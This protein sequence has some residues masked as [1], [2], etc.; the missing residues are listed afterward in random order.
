MKNW[1]TLIGAALLGL[2]AAAI[3]V[4]RGWYDVSASSGHTEAV[5]R[6][7]A[8]TMERSVRQRAAGIQA[9]AL[10]GAALAKRGA[11]C[12]RDHCEQC[13]GG[14]GV[15]PGP[16][17]MGLQPLPGQ[18]VDTASRFT[19]AEIYWIT[20]HGIKM[21]GMPAWELRM[22]DRDLWAVT[23]FVAQ[24]PR[25]TPAAYRDTTAANANTCP[26]INETC[27]TGPCP[28]AATADLA[29]LAP[30]TSNEAARLAFRQYGCVGCH[31]IP[32]IVGFEVH[33]GPPLHGWARRT[34]IA[35]R[36]PN[37]ADDLVHFIRHPRQV[38]PET[39]MPELGVTEAHARMM[40]TYLLAQH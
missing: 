13:H 38:D 21:S 24:L 11:G 22:T 14:P 33:V 23:A 4:W 35:G 29:P 34:R 25:I 1:L 3:F 6:L 39:A 10:D 15:S 12:Y 8:A 7:L 27:T 30:R 40:A 31:Q 16:A 32:G 20:R 36:L 9:P 17:S 26:S 5:H 28:E 18:L 19:A 37:T 2:A